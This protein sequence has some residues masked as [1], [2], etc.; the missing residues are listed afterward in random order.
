MD[1]ILDAHTEV[2]IERIKEHRV[3]RRLGRCRYLIEHSSN[4]F[5]DDSP[6]S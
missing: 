3:V 4:V 5:K 2:T 1:V 6:R